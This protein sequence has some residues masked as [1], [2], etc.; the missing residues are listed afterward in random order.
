MDL[1]LFTVEEENLICIYDTS[2]RAALIDSLN[3][4]KA[5]FDEPELLEIIEN[6][7]KKL[8]AMTD[9]DY[10]ALIFHPAYHGDEDDREVQTV[11]HPN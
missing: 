4:V 11:C 7:I 8:Q 9:A 5:D 3:A 6:A 10:S 2:S 1:N